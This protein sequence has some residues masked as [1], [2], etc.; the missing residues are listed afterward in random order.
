MQTELTHSTPLLKEDGSL[1]QVGWARYPILDCNLEKAA[2]YPRGLRLL[3]FA[4]IKR[5]DYY[6]IFTPRRFF[7]ATIADLGYAANLFVYTMDLENGDLHEEGLV[8]PFGL[9]VRL[10]QQTVGVCK[11]QAKGVCLH[12][13]T[14]PGLRQISVDWPSFHD[15][16]GIEAEISLSQVQGHESMNIVIPIGQR[17]FYYNHK[18]NCLPASGRLKYGDYQEELSPQTCLGQLDWGR[19]VWEYS[20]FWNWASAS[21][22]LNGGRTVGLNLGTGFGD[23][24]AATEDA[25]VLDGRVYKLDRVHWDYVSG[26][27]MQPWKF[28]DDHGRLDLIFTPFKDRTA[29]TH[30]GIIDS[31]VHQMFG[32]YRGL[33]VAD[34]GEKIRLD[35]LLGFAEEHKARW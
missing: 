5:W 9:G 28:R 20:S 21:G 3:Q 8:V 34:D 1:A 16:R 6:A 7:S 23:T 10:S 24:S 26:D 12:F 19:G 22:F 2:F 31:E 17:R 32:H 18:I 4:R 27:Y 14:H 13:Q 15:G 35:G 11:Y 29:T 33:V 30:L 25:L